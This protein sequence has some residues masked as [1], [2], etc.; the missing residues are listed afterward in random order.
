MEHNIQTSFV[1][2]RNEGYRGHKNNS[3][4]FIINLSLNYTIDPFKLE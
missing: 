2:P 1:L 3:C 4:S